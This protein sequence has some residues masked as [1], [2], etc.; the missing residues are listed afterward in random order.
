MTLALRP[1]ADTLLVDN[2]QIPCE[3]PCHATGAREDL[4]NNTDFTRMYRL[5]AQG[6]RTYGPR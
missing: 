2:I 4:V 6:R 5:L 1:S 3:L